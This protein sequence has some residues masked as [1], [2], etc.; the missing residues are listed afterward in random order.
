MVTSNLADIRICLCMVG[1]LVGP[2][3]IRDLAELLFQLHQLLDSQPIQPTR[4]QKTR[5]RRVWARLSEAPP[6]ICAPGP[7]P[8]PWPSAPLPSSERSPAGQPS[9]TRGYTCKKTCTPPLQRWDT[10]GTGQHGKH[11]RHDSWLQERRQRHEEQHQP[12]IA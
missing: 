5:R 2:R 10:A 11:G 8:T 7:G 3:F 4:D 1:L 12:D 6:W 9:A